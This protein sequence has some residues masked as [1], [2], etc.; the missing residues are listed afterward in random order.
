MADIEAR[1]SSEKFP[2]LAVAKAE[3]TRPCN[4]SIS[5]TWL[6][7]N[8]EYHWS[9]PS[10]RRALVELVAK[11]AEQ[12]AKKG[13]ERVAKTGDELV[14][15]PVARLFAKLAAVPAAELVAKPAAV[16]G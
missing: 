5:I 4:S 11:G 8:S 3:P 2:D 16:P 1:A 9:P 12:V 15:K 7:A 6:P 10:F 13:A 14:A